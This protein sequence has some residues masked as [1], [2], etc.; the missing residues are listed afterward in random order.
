MSVKLTF[1]ISVATLP[2]LAL[3]QVDNPSSAYQLGQYVGYAFV[4]V[5]AIL[6]LKKI[7][8]K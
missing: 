3:A 2:Q 4:A 8:K 7:F 1:G 6:I 5:L